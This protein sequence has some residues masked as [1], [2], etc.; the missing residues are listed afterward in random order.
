VIKT[1]EN[2]ERRTSN[3]ESRTQEVRETFEHFVV[4]SY[5]RFDLVLE[6]GEGNYVW[7]ATSR[8]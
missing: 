4:S 7:G 5:V 3:A 8:S 1:E 2:V 6:R